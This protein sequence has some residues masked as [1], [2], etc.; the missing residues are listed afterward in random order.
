VRQQLIRGFLGVG[1]IRALAIPLSLAC[2]I[3]VARM[4][5]PERYGQY[6]FVLAIVPL[7]ALP[8]VGGVQ[9]LLMREVARYS[10]SDAWGRLRGILRF[11]HGWVIGYSALL[12]PLVFV[13][14]HLAGV[15]DAG[16]RPE[17]LGL[18]AFMV[19]LLGLMAL[20]NGAL[21]GLGAV[22]ASEVP[23]QIIRPL[24]FLVAVSILGLSGRMSPSL[25]IGG[26]LAAGGLTV[27]AGLL[28][29]RRERP[30]SI[31]DH[32]ADFDL[33]GWSSTLV[34]M[35]L[36]GVVGTL[37]AQIGVLLLGTLGDDA[38]VAAL[39]IADS[40]ARLALVSLTLVNMV[41]PPQI[42]RYQQDGDRRGL[43]LLARQSA[44]AALVLAAPVA[45]AFFVFGEPLVRL[46]FGAQYADIVPLPLAILAFGYLVSVF[47]GS[48]GLLLTMSGFEKETLRGQVIALLVNVAACGLLIPTFGAVGAATGATLGLVVWNVVLAIR[49]RKLLGIRPTA[50]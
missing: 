25:A 49:V 16:G 33:R 8:V 40:G 23:M 28:L 37:N 50:V 6:V 27:A 32:A 46:L 19:P 2:S 15:A 26:Q 17:L 30:A 13:V 36:I 38:A 20:Q 48:V 43:Q 9:R 39:G 18:A 12:I 3:I 7:L 47:F 44:R 11:S 24:A 31:G 22:A 4:L 34:P 42:V 35:T 29:M 5:G 1:A 14:L 45:L 41:I 21:K 10:R